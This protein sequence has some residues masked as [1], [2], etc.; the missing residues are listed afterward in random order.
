MSL[1]VRVVD[2]VAA[3]ESVVDLIQPIG[4]CGPL[5][6]YKCHDVMQNISKAAFEQ[7]YNNNIMII[8]TIKV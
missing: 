5:T 7:S 1:Q 4:V 3:T 6:E 2:T 8:I